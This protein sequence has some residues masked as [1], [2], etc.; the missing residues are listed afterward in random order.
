MFYQLSPV[1]QKEDED[2]EIRKKENQ[3]LAWGGVRWNLN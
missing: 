3:I 1:L 2:D